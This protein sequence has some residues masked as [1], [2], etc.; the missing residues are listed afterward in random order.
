MLIDMHIHCHE[1]SP[2]MVKEYL[3]R[4]RLVCVSDDPLSSMKTMRLA[5]AYPDIT[6]CVGIHP[7]SIREYSINDLKNILDTAVENNIK[8]LGEIGLDKRFTPETFN[9]Q[10]EFLREAVVY[11]REYGLILNI[12][13]AGAWKEVFHE[14]YRGGIEKAFFH[15]YTG[16]Q[17][18]LNS[19]VEAG[20]Y[21]GLNP[22]WRIQVKHREIITRVPVENI[23]TE[24]DAPYEYHGLKLMPDLIP[25]SI[26]YLAS[27]TGSS[28]R[29]IEEK[30]WGNY[31]K[32]IGSK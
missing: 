21:V 10:L 31:L 28:V 19:I 6:P 8:C 16:P 20:Y 30:I 22:A 27:I 24:S 14:V 2:D 9:K 1:L 23:L 5:E 11:A 29:E 26:E 7:W 17:D 15:W 25:G 13:A 18:L 32:I 4:Y 12:H 3:G